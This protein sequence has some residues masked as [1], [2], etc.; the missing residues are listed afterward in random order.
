MPALLPRTAVLVPAALIAAAACGSPPGPGDTSAGWC[1]AGSSAAYLAA[2]RVVFTG[3]MLP[4]PTVQTGSGSVLA[5]PARVR[6]AR[7][8]KGDGPAIVTVATGIRDADGGGVVSEDGIQPQ[9]GQ[10]WTIYTTSHHAPSRPQSARAPSRPMP[11]PDPACSGH[12]PRTQRP[13]PPHS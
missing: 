7:Y 5:S 11:H 12:R 10:R 3:V 2:A 13:G 1:A 4:G 9:A 8:L 6:V